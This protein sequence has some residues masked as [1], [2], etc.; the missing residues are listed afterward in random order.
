[1]KEEKK[2]KCTLTGRSFFRI[3]SEAFF[4]IAGSL[5]RMSVTVARSVEQPPSGN[6]V[7]AI[8]PSNEH[9]FPSMFTTT[10]HLLSH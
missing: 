3:N 5:L 8:R 10:F 4:V 6:A 2:F 9:P 1:M 7:D